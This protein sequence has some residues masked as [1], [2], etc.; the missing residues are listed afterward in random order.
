MRRY[1]AVALALAIVGLIAPVSAQ[2]D[3]KPF[4]V[5]DCVP[6]D[7]VRF[8]EGSITKRVK[9]FDGVPLDADVTL[10]ATGSSSLPLV[11]LLHG[12]G[13]SKPGL[14]EAKGLAQGGYAVLGYTARGFGNSCGSAESRA[15]DPSG[16]ARGWTHVADT[17]YEAH[18]TQ[19]LAGLLAD[20]ALID[21]LRIG[22][23]GPSYGGA[24]SLELAVL[25][26]LVRRLDGVYVPWLSPVRKL[27]MRIA[28]AAPLVPWSDLV[29]SL[30]PN[31][32]TLDYTITKNGAAKT[33]VGV[34]KQSFVSGLFATGAIGY[35]AP[36]GVDPTADF[37]RWNSILQKGEPYDAAV[38]S[39]I[40]DEL[41]RNHSAYYLPRDELPAP[42]FIASGFT[43]DLFAVNEALRFVNAYPGATFG[44]MYL[45]F[46]HPRA[47]NKPADT[48]RVALRRQLWFD[49]YVKGDLT[50]ST[51]PAVEVLTE[52]C[53]ASAPSGGPFTAASW[54]TA[55]PG[56]VRF[57][58]W[59]AHTVSS[60]G[61]TLGA[62]VEPNTGGGACVKTSSATQSGTAT[63]LL[64]AAT[65]D[66][67]TLLGSPT[68]LA[69]LAVP[70]SVAPANTELAARLWDV[71]GDGT[72]TLV[73]R[74]VYRPSQSGRIVFQLWEGAWMF[75]PGHRAKLELLG[76][77]APYLRASN[78]A[79]TLG[80]SNLQLRLPTHDAP[81]G[82]QVRFPA[83]PVIPG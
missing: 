15:A 35:L 8:C 55:H 61:D 28:A 50:V 65:G 75:A 80:I 60:T 57:N 1:G 33:P 67:Y 72:Q 63:Y 31:G 24:Q 14:A 68:V 3:V 47:Q 2:A 77:D 43:D 32:R 26:D 12:W 49:R 30:L 11:V 73:S 19:Y 21:P 37:Q 18:D 27:P 38:V 82:G 66:G 7:G 20:Q 22:V 9:S 6:Q 58:D 4:G 39:P 10:P 25:H 36:P 62:T 17:R 81:D 23:T 16:C 83:A 79:F 13:S 56:E 71:A 76:R 78:F 5:L 74:G 69:D 48:A 53:P 45:D 34:L 64:P 29:Y 54:S 41:T 40:I 59:Q 52:T 46:G 42:T 44:Q 51:G 70:A